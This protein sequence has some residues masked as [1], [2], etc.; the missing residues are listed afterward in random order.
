MNSN[1]N[2][3]GDKAKK[4]AN[5]SRCRIAS[6][7]ILA[8][9]AA[10][11]S[12][13]QNVPQLGAP[14]APPA[15]PSKPTPFTLSGVYTLSG[16]GDKS[17]GKAYNSDT[18]DVS[19]VYVK[20]GGDLTL[21]EPAITTSGDTSSDENSSFYG[22]NAAVLGG[23][24]GKI[25]ITGGS[26]TTGGSGA[27]AVYA[28]GSGASITMV[29][30][31]IVATGEGAHGVMT[32][33]G[34]TLNLTDLDVS[35]TGANAAAIATDKGGGT[36]TVAGGT[37]TTAGEKSPAI[38]CTGIIKA[39]DAT[40]TATGAEAAIIDGKNS[41]TLVNTKL[42]G[43]KSRGVMIYQTGPTN[44]AG[45]V[46]TFNMKGGS[47]LAGEGPLFY[48][49]NTTATILVSGVN[50]NASS[51]ILVK[52][53]AD[54]WGTTGSNG[55]AVNFTAD[56]EALTGDLAA[57]SPSTIVAKLQN[58]TTLNG[59]V[60]GA[61]ISLDSTSI[62]TLTGDSTITVLV[63]AQGAPNRSFT[64]IVGNGHDAHYDASLT[65]NS[66]L[67]GKTYKLASG[68][69]LIPTPGTTRNNQNNNGQNNNGRGYG[70]PGGG[71]S[72]GF[73]GGGGGGGHR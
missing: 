67:G 11:V 28:T 13:G 3:A 66:W 22:L 32:S 2:I 55:G 23:R 35:T 6:A 26:I 48:V 8:A 61:A 19:A 70:G 41:I 64:N 43:Q 16:K 71:G 29:K 65:G 30:T 49:T 68:G 57:E 39:S 24:G 27:N 7:I 31:K 44:I 14:P 37:F 5:C 62:W 53:A 38:Y 12:S 10:S 58:E 59:T 21:L 50:L 54:E 45:T 9:I 15:K 69:K 33:A 1:S 42:S 20:A 73:G 18:K 36:I 51:G 4:T 40:L 47:L 60:T 17:T 56:H 46:G 34:G 72:G 52:A 63:D 25:K